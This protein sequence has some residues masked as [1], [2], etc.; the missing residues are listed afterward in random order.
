MVLVGVRAC[1][2]FLTLNLRMFQNVTQFLG[3]E[4]VVKMT[5]KLQNPLLSG[6]LTC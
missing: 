2:Q 3:S 5:K 1:Q 6:F 4:A